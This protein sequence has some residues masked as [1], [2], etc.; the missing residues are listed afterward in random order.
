MID[1]GPKQICA[2]VATM[3]A[4]GQARAVHTSPKAEVAQCVARCSEGVKYGWWYSSLDVAIGFSVD[5][6]DSWRDCMGPG[7][8]NSRDGQRIDPLSLP[9]GALVAAPVEFTMVQPADGNGELVADFPPH[10]PLLGKLEVVGIRRRTAADQARLSSHKP[11]MVAVAF[12]LRFAD[13]GDFPRTRLA[14]PRPAA[15]SV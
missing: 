1:D 4:F 10:R 2:V 11:Q 6:G 3:S 13:D 14:L 15:V 8:K 9:P 5:R 7:P 12:A